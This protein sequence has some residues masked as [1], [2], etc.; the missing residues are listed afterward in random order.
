MTRAAADDDDIVQFPV[1]RRYLPQVIKLLA[2]LEE[3]PSASRRIRRDNRDP[4][5]TKD[6]LK[7]LRQLLATRQ[8]ALDLLD[9]TASLDGEPLTFAELCEAT[10]ESRAAARGELASLTSIVRKYFHRSQW[11]ADAQW[12][13]EGFCYRMNPLT[14]VLWNEVRSGI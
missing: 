8:T 14:A 2:R 6:E 7:W 11:P 13:S 12:E 5:W 10:G 9:F 4:L 3:S 1:P